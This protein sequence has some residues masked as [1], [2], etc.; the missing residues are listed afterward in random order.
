MFFTDMFCVK[1][2]LYLY[3]VD[4]VNATHDSLSVNTVR[5]GF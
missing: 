5:H 4:I 1:N 2:H 3:F